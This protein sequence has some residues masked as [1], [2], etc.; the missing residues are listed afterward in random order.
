MSKYSKLLMQAVSNI[1]G[2]KQ[3]EGLAGMFTLGETG[4]STD[5][6][7]S[8]LDDFELISFLVIM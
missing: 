1:I 3:E 4:L 7:L 5:S 8:G 6:N 2:K